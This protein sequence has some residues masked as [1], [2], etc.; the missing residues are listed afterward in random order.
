[1][2]APK[3][4]IPRWCWTLAKV[5]VAAGIVVWMFQQDIIHFEEL[6]AALVNWHWLAVALVALLVCVFL[7]SI[8]WR[9]LLRAQDL[10]AGTLELFNLTMTGLFFALVAPGGIGGD[11]VKAI[12]VTRGREKKAEAATTVFLDRFLGLATLFLVGAV[13]VGLKCRTLWDTQ[14]A[15]LDRFGLPG[16]RIL[17]IAIT[18]GGVAI[19]AFA[20]LVTNKRVRRSQ[21]LNRLSRG[22]PFRQTLV[23]VYD[24][25]HLY[26]DKPGALVLAAAV[27]V[28]AQMPLYIVYYLYGLAVGAEIAWWHCALI[29]PPAMVIRV[30]PLM[31]AGAGQGMVAM[32]LLFPLVGVQKGAAIGAVGD[33]MFFV[34]CLIGGLFFVFGKTNYSDI[35]AAAEADAA[36]GTQ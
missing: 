11:A 33:A 16:G 30:L 7:Q 6:K 24:A 5:G 32:G 25:M 26:G 35:R 20:L 13:M 2:S 21:L 18:A 19:M 36:P 15:G 3:K 34:T 29:V 17:V 12:Y 10:Q 31:P 23:K 9:I 22:V 1:M 28:V 27:S 8:R 4:K 14:V